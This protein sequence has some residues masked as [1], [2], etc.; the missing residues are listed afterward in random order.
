MFGAESDWHAEKQAAFKHKIANTEGLNTRDYKSA[1]EVCDL[2]KQVSANVLS[3][4][5]AASLR[6]TSISEAYRVLHN[7]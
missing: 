6:A 3:V 1:A 2:I 4:T 5:S 7:G